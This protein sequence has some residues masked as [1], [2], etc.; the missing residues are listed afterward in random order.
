LFWVV[1]TLFGFDYHEGPINWGKW[2]LLTVVVMGVAAGLSR[3]TTRV[4]AQPLILLEEGIHSVGEGRLEPLQVSRTGDEIEDLGHSFNQMIVRLAETQQEVRQHQ[5]LL[6]ERIHQRTEQLEQAMQRAQAASQAKSEF[7]ANMSHELRTPMNGVLGMIDIV[8]DSPLT[9]E[10]REHLDTAQRCANSLLSLLNDILDLS[11]IEAGKMVLERIPFDLRVLVDDIVRAHKARASKKGITLHLDVRPEVPRRITA[12]PLRVRQ[13]LSNL[14]ANA[15]KFTERG[16]V[17]VRVGR[18]GKAEG[19]QLH[20]EVIDSGVGIAADKLQCIFD[21]FTQADGSISRKYGGTGLGLTITKML[22]DMHEGGIEVESEPGKGSTFRVIFPSD[23][24]LTDGVEDLAASSG[25]GAPPAKDFAKATILVVEDN[26]VNQKVVTAILR[27]KG[28]HVDI[29]NHGREALEYLELLAYD[30]VLMDV[31]MPILDGLE[32]TRTIRR[33]SRFA[34]LPIVAMTAHAMS[35]DRER[36][37]AAGMNGYIAKPVNPSTLLRTIEEYLEMRNAPPAV[38]DWSTVHLV[39]G[40]PGLLAEVQRLFLR[41]APETVEKLHSLLQACDLPA[42]EL[43][44][45]RLR[46]WATQVAAARVAD[47]ASRIEISARARDLDGTRHNLVSLE[48]ELD[49]AANSLVATPKAV[50]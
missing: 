9:A 43:E 2:T 32:T 44:A 11:K 46:N 15:I 30:L 20:L 16:S 40:D 31:Q 19:H 37:L 1:V 5:E 13:I 4:L 26:H 18:A 21:K 7:L 25:L 50:A 33:D 22:V 47:A 23:V 49:L 41:V 34:Q 3:F 38:E 36:C 48:Q 14:L 12:D 29:A 27:K 42:T 28:Y 39:P 17:R 8:L 45:T 10:Q 6:E 35:G 24:C